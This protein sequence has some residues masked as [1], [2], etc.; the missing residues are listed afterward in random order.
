MGERYPGLR[1]LEVGHG[2]LMV[3]R[4]ELAICRCGS[5]RR[6]TSSQGGLHRYYY[7]TVWY[8]TVE[9]GTVLYS[10]LYYC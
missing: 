5:G 6:R 3:G 1:D 8:S 7:S 2:D 4:E 9:Y 10:G